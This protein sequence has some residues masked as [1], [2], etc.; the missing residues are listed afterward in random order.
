MNARF[1]IY[2]TVALLCSIAK[3]EAAVQKI[4]EDL[5]A[6]IG[7]NA[8]LLLLATQ[9]AQV[10]WHMGKY[11]IDKY[12]REQQDKDA[13]V[14]KLKAEFHQ[15]REEVAGMLGKISTKVD[16]VSKLPNEEEILKRLSDRMEFM[17]YKAARDLGIK[18]NKR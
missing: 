8:I 14:K 5:Y 6:G 10:V 7:D 13:E 15:F 4:G 18:D 3:A 12:F 1:F 2:T 16:H 9:L 11:I 17:V